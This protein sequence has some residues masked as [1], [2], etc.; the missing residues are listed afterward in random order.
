MEKQYHAEPQRYRALLRQCPNGKLFCYLEKGKA[1]P[2]SYIP[3]D[4]GASQD[5]H[6]PICI[7]LLQQC[8]SI[9]EESARITAGKIPGMDYTGGWQ[10]GGVTTVWYAPREPVFLSFRYAPLHKNG[11]NMQVFQQYQ[12]LGLFSTAHFLTFPP[13]R[14]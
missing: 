9:H 10:A 4:T 14:F 2:D 12:I 8:Q 5:N 13:D 11:F 1:I 3:Y 7:C 6:F